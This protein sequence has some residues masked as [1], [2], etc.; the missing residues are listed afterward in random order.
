MQK[1]IGISEGITTNSLP[2]SRRENHKGK[3]E[4]KLHFEERID[5]CQL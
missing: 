4:I 1:A 3:G 5:F 2:G